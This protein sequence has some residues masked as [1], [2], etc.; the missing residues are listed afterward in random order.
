MSSSLAAPMVTA[1]SATWSE[2]PGAGGGGDVTRQ[3]DHR[4]ALVQRIE[5]SVDQVRR[6][7]PGRAA[8]RHRP[9]GQ[10]GLGDRREHHELLACLTCT[11]STEP[12]RRIASIVGFSA[13]PTMP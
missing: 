9:P 7:R 4:R 10:A 13:S 3:R 1:G 2:P 6:A 8:D 12:L 11:K 5:Q